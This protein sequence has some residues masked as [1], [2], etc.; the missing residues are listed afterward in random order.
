MSVQIEGPKDNFHRSLIDSPQEKFQH[1]DSKATF[2]NRIA[3][4][5]V[6]ATIAIGVSILCLTLFISAATPLPLAVF[7]LTLALPFLGIYHKNCIQ[8]SFIYTRNAEI[9]KGTLQELEKLKDHSSEDIEALLRD[10]GIEKENIPLD[11]LRKLNPKDP[12]KALLPVIAR[13]RYFVSRSMQIKAKAY[14]MIFQKEVSSE[15]ALKLR[16]QAWSLLER[17]A[18]PSLFEAAVLYNVITHPDTKTELA[19][20]GK[21]SSCSL[22]ERLSLNFFDSKDPYFVFEDKEKEPLEFDLVKNLSP[23]DLHRLLFAKA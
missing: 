2:Y 18:V 17:E 6:V 13:I 15:T 5:T 3:T 7:G 16:E 19:A 12:L 20:L 11:L 21:I 8:K 14:Q 10:V 9:E 23:P 4:I 22:E 1:Y